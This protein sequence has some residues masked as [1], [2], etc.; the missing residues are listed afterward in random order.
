MNDI[1]PI[2]FGKMIN[3]IETL[4]EKVQSLSTE[5]STMNAKISSG[6]GLML[7]VLVTAGG[8]GAGATKVLEYVFK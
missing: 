5:V 8:L 6:K 3:A 2:Q 1:D 4:E 7:G